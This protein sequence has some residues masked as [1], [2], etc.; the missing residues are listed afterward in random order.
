MTRY[1]PRVPGELPVTS[2]WNRAT[3]W[4]TGTLCAAW[5]FVGWL[6]VIPNQDILVDNIQAQSLTLDPRIVLA[7]P[8]QK[9][10]GPLEYPATVLAEWLLPGNYYVSSVVRVLLA[11][12]TGLLAGR[13]AFA[14]FP[15]TRPWA[16]IAA[17]AVGPTIIHGLQAPGVWW[18][19]PNY[20]MAW[21][22]ITGGALTLARSTEAYQRAPGPR[23]R[24]LAV[25]GGLLFGLGLYAHPV[26]ILFAVPMA[27]LVIAV[28]R[29]RVRTLAWALLGT[30]A[31]I[32]PGIVSYFVNDE[33]NVWDPSHKPF[34][35]PEW[36]WTMGRRVLGADGISDPS[37]ALLPYAMG[38]SPTQQPFSGPMQTA[39]VFVLLLGCLA[40]VVRGSWVAVRTRTWLSAA[41]GLALAWLVA[42]LTMVLF[43]TSADPVWHY[44]AGLA[45]LAWISI[46]ALPSLTPQRAVGT[47]VTVLAL[48]IFASSTWAQ[49]SS[50]LLE[51]PE[52]IS[53]KAQTLQV[54]RST[55]DELVD[56]DVAVIF[57]SYGDAVP[58]GY[59]SNWSLRTV[60]INYNRFPLNDSEKTSANL[61]VALRADGEPG[62][63][64]NAL[65]RVEGQCTVVERG[66]KLPAG[67][68]LV[69]DCPTE[70]LTN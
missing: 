54:W 29:V 44:S 52:R 65:S 67:T 11:F 25:M 14:L 30:A 42:A 59:A 45:I 23:S 10:G 38:F 63:A 53:D 61:R 39:A 19:Q 1:G 37:T 17:V 21:L 50:Y 68:Y 40:V 15:R 55:A 34:I 31:G 49:N 2:R 70:V 24:W 48:I 46:G 26:I 36:L 62:P 57:G 5:A 9:H 4:I 8:G 22:L 12:L 51:L 32:V 33:V 58:I 16:L 56:R 66:L 7:F 13:L 43:I 64:Q 3:P 6:G 20:D 69:A 60:T 18:L 35:Y 28:K 47:T 41:T 27:A